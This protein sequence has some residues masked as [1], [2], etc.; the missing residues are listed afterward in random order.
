MR[1]ELRILVLT[2][3]TGY[4][5][6]LAQGQHIKPRTQTVFGMESH[7][8]KNPSDV[9]VT[10]LDLLK[11]HP[12]VKDC[13][14]YSEKSDPPSSWFVASAIRLQANNQ[15]DLIVLPRDLS[16]DNNSCLFHLH[17]IPV[18]IFIKTPTG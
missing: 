14:D 1:L 13:L 3:M 4:T 11:N 18:W 5:S 8:I 15:R 6:C 2:F 10:V 17:S 16:P 9:P 7:P 12:L